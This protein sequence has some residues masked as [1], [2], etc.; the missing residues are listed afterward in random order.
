MKLRCPSLSDRIL[1][2]YVKIVENNIDVLFLVNKEKGLFLNK[3]NY[4]NGL[5]ETFKFLYYHVRDFNIFENYNS[6][7]LLT[8][9]TYLKFDKDY[10]V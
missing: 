6:L 2:K 4:D 5:I 7:V 10:N 3:I 8:T 9:Y 1:I